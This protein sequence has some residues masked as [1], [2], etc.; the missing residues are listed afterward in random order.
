MAKVMDAFKTIA[1]FGVAVLIAH[2]TRKDVPGS[3]NPD[4][5]MRG[6]SDIL[7]AVDCH[8]AMRRING[9]EYVELKQTK[10]R[11]Q[12]PAPPMK[13]HFTEI[14]GRTGFQLVELLQ[15]ASDRDAELKEA[16]LLLVKAE[17]GIFKKLMLAKLIEQQIEIEER[18]LATLLKE[19]V[20]E[21]KLVTKPGE[22]TK[23][24]YYL[25]STAK[26]AETEH[27]YD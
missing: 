4:N 17:P 18:K 12:R 10:N 5:S 6:S 2:H 11:F 15:T 24:H 7:A 9:G 20:N 21:G 26:D 1:D 22:R 23:I 14:D 16:I 3:Y 27:I 8:L 25:P 19:L 13:L